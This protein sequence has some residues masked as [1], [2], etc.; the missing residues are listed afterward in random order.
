M[1]RQAFNDFGG[2]NFVYVTHAPLAGHGLAIGNSDAGAFLPAMLEGVKAQVRQF[3]C[4]S[5]TIDRED[6]A[7]VMKLVFWE[8]KYWEEM[9]RELQKF[10]SKSGRISLWIISAVFN[11]S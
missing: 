11:S 8:R 10:S 3:R 6:P 5:V 4:L 7:V 1:S 9:R 2:K